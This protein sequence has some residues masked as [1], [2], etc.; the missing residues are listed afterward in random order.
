MKDDYYKIND[1]Y[2]YLD[3]YFGKHAYGGGKHFYPY[4]IEDTL[5][6]PA[7]RS[8]AGYI[9]EHKEEGKEYSDDDS[10]VAFL[11]CLSN[12]SNYIIS[13]DE[14]EE[15][16][17]GIDAQKWYDS[18]IASTKNDFIREKPL[19]LNKHYL[20]YIYITKIIIPD[21]VINRYFNTGLFTTRIDKGGGGGYTDINQIGGVVTRF[22]DKESLLLSINPAIKRYGITSALATESDIKEV[23]VN[24]SKFL[25]VDFADLYNKYKSV[26]NSAKKKDTNWWFPFNDKLYKLLETEIKKQHWQTYLDKLDASVLKK[27]LTQTKTV[28]SKMEGTKTFYNNKDTFTTII[29]NIDTIQQEIISIRDNLSNKTNNKLLIGNSVGD[30]KSTVDKEATTKPLSGKN[31]ITPF[32]LKQGITTIEEVITALNAFKIDGFSKLGADLTAELAKTTTK[33][34]QWEKQFVTPIKKATEASDSWKKYLDTT[35]GS[36][37]KKLLDLLEKTT[38]SPEEYYFKDKPVANTRDLF[39]VIKQIQD[40]IDSLKLNPESLIK[41]PTKSD[42]HVSTQSNEDNFKDQFMRIILKV[43]MIM[44]DTSLNKDLEWGDKLKPRCNK[45]YSDFKNDIF[46]KND[47]V[48]IYLNT[49]SVFINEIYNQIA[50]LNDIKS[51]FKDF[52]K[53]I[54]GII[55]INSIKLSYLTGCL[56]VYINN[57]NIFIYTYIPEG[58]YTPEHIKYIAN[59]DFIFL[60]KKIVSAKENDE[61]IK[62][63]VIMASISEILTDVKTNLERNDSITTYVAK[64]ESIILLAQSKE[65]YL[66]KSDIIYFIVKLKELLFITYQPDLYF[67][68]KCAYISLKKLFATK[69]FIKETK[70]KF[71]TAKLYKSYSI[72]E[73]RYIR[74]LIK[75]AKKNRFYANPEFLSEEKR[76]LWDIYGFYNI[77]LAQNTILS[78][79]L[80][81]EIYALNK[82]FRSS[83]YITEE[84]IAKYFFKYKVYL[85]TPEK[86]KILEDKNEYMYIPSEFNKGI[87]DILANRY[88]SLYLDITRDIEGNYLHDKMQDINSDSYINIL[89]IY[90]KTMHDI[91]IESDSKTASSKILLKKYLLPDLKSY[92]DT[93]QK[94][95]IKFTYKI[96]TVNVNNNIRLYKYYKLLCILSQLYAIRF[97][98]FTKIDDDFVKCK[99]Y[100]IYEEET[101]PIYTTIYL[102]CET[103]KLQIIPFTK[104]YINSI[105]CPDILGLFRH[106]IFK[107]DSNNLVTPLQYTIEHKAWIDHNMS[108]FKIKGIKNKI[109]EALLSEE[110]FSLL[111]KINKLLS[112]SYI[113]VNNPEIIKTFFTIII[114][115]LVNGHVDYF[116]IISDL[117]RLLGRII[118]TVEHNVHIENEPLFS[119]LSKMFNIFGIYPNLST[120]KIREDYSSYLTDEKIST[121]EI[122]VDY[123]PE[124]K[125]T[126]VNTLNKKLAILLGPTYD[127]INL[128]NLFNGDYR[129]KIYTFYAKSEGIPIPMPEY[130]IIDVNKNPIKSEFYNLHLKTEM[131]LLELLP[132]NTEFPFNKILDYYEEKIF[133]RHD[134]DFTEMH[135]HAVINADYYQVYNVLNKTGLSLYFTSENFL[136]EYLNLVELCYSHYTEYS[137]DDFYMHV[138]A[139]YIKLL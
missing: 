29:T 133:T 130:I 69:S 123:D 121:D 46:V 86:I 73:K 41:S 80:P 124:Y 128:D 110:R 45:I 95:D 77:A 72:K 42:D 107:N 4:F 11:E 63:A 99:Y 111:N 104:D 10:N 50:L 136:T 13:T 66:H 2:K 68:L 118:N 119:L 9:I 24:V 62:E 59:E 21:E 113:L 49:Q 43:H 58:V 125:P 93:I 65:D 34:T 3:K 33:S 18:I 22:K 12:I 47:T 55:C 94:K 38:L 84:T 102:K 44:I 15:L 137:Y 87:I 39:R 6:I 131:T 75:F 60:D 100:V 16:Y 78:L 88:T 115:R 56:D 37:L 127:S 126:Y 25:I 129:G 26:L 120:V 35:A 96:D 98:C 52:I 90:Y 101:K 103:D 106:K 54:T 32:L 40:E 67:K 36:E 82:K 30:T 31:V 116:I 74:D 108:D 139:S 79:S 132:F 17:K 5:G 1:Y 89:T 122:E 91:N 23:I 134:F 71:I 112:L 53:N 57:K 97:I 19:N 51:K 27:L 61:T 92:H 138:A 135:K 20:Y 109:T 64:I 7:E 28:N 14:I 114:S 8:I 117:S 81:K 70:G 76:Q 48:S 83:D 85:Q 105:K